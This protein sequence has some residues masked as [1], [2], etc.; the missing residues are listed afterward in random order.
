MLAA[1]HDPAVLELEDDAAVDVQVL[2]GALGDVVMDADHAAVL[3][4]EHA[5]QIRPERATRLGHV[6]AET[7]DDGLPSDDVAR[8]RA[9]AR[10]V[11]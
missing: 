8:E 6:S 11:P 4:G 3:V 1:V 7:G 5:L 2:A 10:G 9:L